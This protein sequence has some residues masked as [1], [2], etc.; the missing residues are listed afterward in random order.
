MKFDKDT[1]HYLSWTPSSDGDRENWTISCWIK[2]GKIGT[3]NQ[4]MFESG[5]TAIRFGSDVFQWI[6]G[7]SGNNGENTTAATTVDPEWYHLVFAWDSSAR[8]SWN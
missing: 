7:G 6:D 4:R 5:S 3:A 2:R 1:N 8:C